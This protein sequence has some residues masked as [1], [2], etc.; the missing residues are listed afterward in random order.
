MERFSSPRDLDQARQSAAQ[1]RQGRLTLSLCSGT[2]CLANRSRPV[3]EA[4]IAELDKAGAA[5]KVIVKRTGCHGFCERGPILVVYPQEICYLSVQPDDVAEIVAKTVLK[6]EL[7]DRLLWKQAGKTF[8]RQSDI[9]FYSHQTRQVLAHNSLMDPAD[10]DD[11]IGYDG[12]AALADVLANRTPQ[13]VIDEIKRAD[14]RGR[15]GGGFPAG[16]KW[17]TTRNA[18]DPVKYVIVNGDEGDPGA[19]MDRSVLEGAP[20]SVLEGL[21]IGAY[22]IGAT[23][24]FFYI[25]QEYPLALTNTLK[26][27][28]Q[29]EARGLLGDNIL[30]SPFSFHVKVHQGAGAF[31]SG[32]SS[33][34]VSAIEGRV[35]EPRL[36]YIRQSVSGLFGKPTCLNNVETWAN[37]PLIIR[38]GADWFR[39]TGTE[40]S[41][42]TKI[43][44][45]VGQVEHTGLVEVPMGT[46]LRQIIYDI[47]GG[48]KSGRK[49]K[50]VQTGGP[51]GGCIPEAHLDTPVD[52]DALT[53]LGSMMGSGGMIVMDESSCMVDVARYFVEFLKE[54]S[55][56]KCLPCREG[57]REMVTILNRITQGQGRPGD[58]AFLEDIAVLLSEAAL[59]GLGTSAANPVISTL[60]YF[61]DEYEAHIH[62]KT[63][64]A[65]VCKALIAYTIDAERCQ[66]CGAC[67]KQC[68]TKAITGE[69]KAA[70]RI[71]QKKCV[72]CG[73][74]LDA[75]PKK[76]RAVAKVSSVSVVPEAVQ[77]A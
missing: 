28:E 27:I 14:L 52:F 68:P 25:R 73:V 20:H 59:C 6:G 8:T 67:A 76:Y 47:G 38:N 69:K 10:I 74:C 15:G 63:C 2:G 46:T 53:Q 48:I 41:K 33:A 72:K 50:A 39:A 60:R 57:I 43:F 61:R 71:D 4:L 12:Y 40:G 56:G 34:L 9:P 22:A 62:A 54:E 75:C 23:A 18:A 32:E 5:D 16:V 44:S 70:H 13:Q 19:Y 31:V 26:A 42:G 58:I 55:C 7:V 36:K 66:G 37:V 30:G 51:S 65:G 24:G 64:P 35:G 11:Y 29:A 3:Y 1:S 77:T 21:I 49:F 45:L 17:E